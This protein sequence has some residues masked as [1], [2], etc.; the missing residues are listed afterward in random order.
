MWDPLAGFQQ[1]ALSNGL[2][3]HAATWDRPWEYIGVVIHAGSAHDPR[4]KEGMAHFFE[5]LLSEGIQGG[6]FAKLREEFD[7]R[8]IGYNFGST[9]ECAN[10]LL[11]RVPLVRDNVSRVFDVVGDMLFHPTFDEFVRRE[12]RVVIE[13]ASEVLSFPIERQWRLE[14][15]KMFWGAWHRLARFLGPCGTPST[16]RA[17]SI[18]DLHAWHARYYVPCNVDIVACGGLA[19]DA[20]R[21]LVSAS[22]FAACRPGIVSTLPSPSEIATYQPRRHAMKFSDHLKASIDHGKIEI[23]APCS[24]STL[25]AEAIARA[26]EAINEALLRHVR[27]R[28]GGDYD[29]SVSALEHPEGFELV[30]AGNFIA[31]L[32]PDIERLVD[33]SL[34]L[35]EDE[36]MITRFVTRAISDWE[37]ID[38]K[39]QDVVTAALSSL[40]DER[41]V[42]TV[43][44]YLARA[45]ALTVLDVRS[46]IHAFAPKKRWTLL[47]AP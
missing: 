39:G 40:A 29:L 31:S 16:I 43:S 12:R 14:R 35:A 36:A 47:C 19:C 38:M 10:L 28:L 11:F 7:Q 23:I 18:A 27:E 30:L 33:E 5:H 42:V 32:A 13:E 25:S 8:S 44:S 1:F 6:S 9:T 20:L 17:I 45:R 15:G 21:D 26:C 4:R 24:R 2:R 46:V 37:F 22:V 34:A 41:Q 3:C